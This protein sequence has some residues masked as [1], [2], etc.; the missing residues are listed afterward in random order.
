MKGAGKY[1]RRQQGCPTIE[2]RIMATK[3][4]G[5]DYNDQ[6]ENNSRGKRNTEED[7]EEHNKKKRSDPS[8]RKK[9]WF[10]LERRQNHLH[11]WKDLY[12]K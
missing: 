5:K 11:G 1:Q 2:G 7:Q 4:N 6:E 8:T 9:G 10:N 3:D 12:A